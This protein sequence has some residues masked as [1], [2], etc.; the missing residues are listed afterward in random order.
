MTLFQLG[1]LGVLGTVLVVEAVRCARHP[2]DRRMRLF[3]AGVWLA[4]AAAISFPELVQQVATAVGIHRGAD[5]VTYLFILG[6][7][8]IAFRLYAGQVHLQRQVTRLV[9]ALALQEA[10]RGPLGSDEPGSDPRAP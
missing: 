3:R 2:S 4:A 8:F 1:A 10:R 7:L 9:R 5:L 6:F